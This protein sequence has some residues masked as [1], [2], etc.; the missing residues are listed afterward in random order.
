MHSSYSASL[1]FLLCPP[2]LSD[3][4]EA[5]QERRSVACWNVMLLLLLLCIKPWK[6]PRS[7]AFDKTP[8]RCWHVAY[9][10]F[11]KLPGTSKLSMSWLAG[12]ITTGKAWE[13]APRPQQGSRWAEESGADLS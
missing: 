2:Y 9:L 13:T 7:T 8:V 5:E 1:R 6:P 4:G 12:C 3:M 11:G 10:A